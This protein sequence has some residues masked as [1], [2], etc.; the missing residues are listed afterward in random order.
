MSNTTKNYSSQNDN[1]NMSRYT[2]TRTN[3]PIISDYLIN[4][5]QRVTK[6]RIKD[7]TMSSGHITFL[8]CL[9]YKSYESPSASFLIS[10]PM[11]L[12]S[13]LCHAPQPNLLALSIYPSPPR[14]MPVAYTCNNNNKKDYEIS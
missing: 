7:A 8:L 11:A 5:I 12:I 13:P 2:S 3:N 9:E 1:K 6:V 10:L 14:S 4:D